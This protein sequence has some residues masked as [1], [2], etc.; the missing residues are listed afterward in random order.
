MIEWIAAKMASQ[1]VKVL[2]VLAALAMPM[3]LLGWVWEGVALHGIEIPLPSGIPFFGP[4]ELIHGALADT[5]AAQA[6][7]AKA[8]KDRDIYKGNAERLG[9]GLDRCNAGVKN[10]AAAGQKLEQAAQA[11]VNL[12]LAEQRDYAKRRAAVDAIR[13]TDA[14]CPSVDSIFTAGFGP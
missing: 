7:Q 3:C 8:E 13:P 5:R 6:A 14:K 9:A 10:L 1:T 11:L 4:W 12:R 2:V